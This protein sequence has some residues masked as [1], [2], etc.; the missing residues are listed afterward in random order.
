[1]RLPYAP[2]HLATNTLGITLSSG[3]DIRIEAIFTDDQF[4]DFANTAVAPAGGNGQ[5]GKIKSALIFNAAATYP[6]KQWGATLF[7]ATKNLTDR[8]YIVDRTR[9][10][11][12][13]MPLLMQGGIEISF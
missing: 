1:L 12:V 10:I 6:L 4:S 11:R 7:L 13:G 3:L 2:E 9:G 8:D 5:V